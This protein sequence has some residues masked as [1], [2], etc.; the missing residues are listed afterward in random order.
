MGSFITFALR[1]VKL[2]CKAQKEVCLCDDSLRAC[3]Y[4]IFIY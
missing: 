3:K 4:D 1:Q 2:E